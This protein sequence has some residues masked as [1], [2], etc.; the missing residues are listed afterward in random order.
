MARNPK[1]RSVSYPP[2]FMTFKP[3]GV[4]GIKLETITLELDEYEAIRLADYEGLEHEKASEAMDISRSTFTRLIERAR[5]KMAIMLIEGSKLV[6][7]G[8]SVHFKENIY[9]CKACN[10]RF[11]ATIN[12]EKKECP[13][14]HSCELVDFAKGFGHGMCCQKSN[15]SESIQ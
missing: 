1:A 5:K 3:A 8:G 4:A 11:R 13:V 14:C 6:I 2:L 15:E 7:D 9:Q 10:H 12:E